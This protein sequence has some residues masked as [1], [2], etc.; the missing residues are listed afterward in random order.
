MRDKRKA[1]ERRREV[2]EEVG[3]HRENTNNGE[4][5]KEATPVVMYGLV[6]PHKLLKKRTN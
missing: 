6:E 5:V 1:N 3:R 2:D 4:V